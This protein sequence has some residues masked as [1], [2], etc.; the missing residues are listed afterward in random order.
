MSQRKMNLEEGIE[1]IDLRG[2]PDDEGPEM[3][4]AILRAVDQAVWEKALVASDCRANY[5]FEADVL[6]RCSHTT[7]LKSFYTTESTIHKTGNGRSSKHGPARSHSIL[8]PFGVIRTEDCEVSGVHYRFELFLKSYKERE[9][10]LLV[11][12]NQATQPGRDKNQL[13]SARLWI[14]P[15]IDWKFN[16][17]TIATGD[18]HPGQVCS[19]VFE[20]ADDKSRHPD[21]YFV[22]PNVGVYEHYDEASCMAVYLVAYYQDRG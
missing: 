5:C 13:R 16:E 22:V 2:I 6:E 4:A 8:E 20:V 1:V 15:H 18:L 17:K 9:D 12:F 14:A 11:V 7:K 3:A 10:V 21:P 19:L